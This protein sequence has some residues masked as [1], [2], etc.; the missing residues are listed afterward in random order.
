MGDIVVGVCYRLPGQGEVG[1]TFFTQLEE[2]L[3]SEALFLKRD[4]KPPIICW[5]GMAAVHGK[6]KSFGECIDG[7]FLR[8]AR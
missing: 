7:T 4:L 3:C 8:K 5:K 1:E 2:S 6:A